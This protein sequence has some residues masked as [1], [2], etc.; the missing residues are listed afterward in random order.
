[1]STLLTRHSLIVSEAA[2]KQELE[3]EIVRIT[4]IAKQQAQDAWAKSGREG[5]GKMMIFDPSNSHI[6]R[7]LRSEAEAIHERIVTAVEIYNA[8]VCLETS[9]NMCAK[10]PREL[11]DMV[12]E[13]LVGGEV[14]V[15]NCSTGV[16]VTGKSMCTSL[17]YNLPRT[18]HDTHAQ[19]YFADSPC[20]ASDQLCS[21]L[22]WRSGR[23][24]PMAAAELR[25]AWYRFNE[26]LI[27]WDICCGY[28]EKQIT[29]WC[30]GATSLLI[31]YLLPQL[32]PRY[33]M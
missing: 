15:N 27:P 7:K 10:L 16:K 14:S 1:V 29:C 11:R 20:T 24:D 2:T 31:E 26:F 30:S 8:A 22:L 25:C 6:V 28:E 19:P 17:V 4:R 9:I 32:Y 33:V 18:G 23:T 21:E 5:K 3:D 13:H 12:Y